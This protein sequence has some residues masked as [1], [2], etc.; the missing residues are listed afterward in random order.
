MLKEWT[1]LGAVVAFGIG[2]ASAT[3]EVAPVDPEAA[4]AAEMAAWQRYMTPGEPHQR[5]AAQSGEWTVSGRF[6]MEPGQPPTDMAGSAR[7]TMI[8]DGRYQQ[9]EYES[10][11]MGM[12]FH[13]MSV[14]GYDNALKK[15]VS[16]WIDT[17]GT[18]MMTCE[19]VA[20]PTGKVTTFTGTMV[21][22]MGSRWAIRQVA[23]DVDA[24]TMFFEMYVTESA[25]KGET[26]S[27]ELTYTRKK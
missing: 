6:W 13:G 27:M 26:K 21:N 15:Y 2:C 14:T 16:W 8:F 22:P 18:G 7:I 1:V 4:K 5:L 24:D 9:Q 25:E 12:P 11:F 20:D 19:G 3:T 17:M 10:A 23:T